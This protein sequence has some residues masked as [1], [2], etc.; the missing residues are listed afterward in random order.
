MIQ[1]IFGDQIDIHGGGM[2][3]IFPHHENEIAQSE[4]CSHKTFVKYWMHW[5][6]INFGAQ[7]MSKSV[8][9][10]VSLREFLEVNPAEVYKWM[11][12]SVHYRSISD[13]SDAAVERA[14]AALARVYSSLALAESYLSSE[15]TVTDT[16]FDKITA[17]AWAKIENALNADFGTPEAF[18]SLFE[19]VRQF[20]SQVRRG[21]KTNPAIQGKALSFQRFV[22]KF[23]QILSL[24]QEPAHEFLIKLDDMLLKKSNLERSHVDAVVAE[25]AKARESKDF[26]KSDELR[27]KLTNMGISVS[28]LPTGSFLGSYQVGG[29]VR[30]TFCGCGVSSLPLNI[31]QFESMNSGHFIFGRTVSS[32]PIAPK[33]FVMFF[34]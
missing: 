12:L 14:T 3:L 15:V 22:K 21:L 17:E 19:V 31:A 34:K 23:G 27:D 20:N 24:F 32:S 29:E 33:T 11:M 2:D 4:G 7:K 28:D 6:M 10:I 18:A 30:R 13:F 5:N 1:E 16:G 9:N 8:G 26:A 25:R